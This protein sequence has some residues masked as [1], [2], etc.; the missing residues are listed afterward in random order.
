MIDPV[1]IHH[2]YLA[3]PVRRLEGPVF[4]GLWAER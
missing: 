4:T 1:F 2:P 3:G